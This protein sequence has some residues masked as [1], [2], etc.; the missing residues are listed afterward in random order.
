MFGFECLASSELINSFEEVI[1]QSQTKV[2]MV[3]D[4]DAHE[5]RAASDV[6]RDG[7]TLMQLHRSD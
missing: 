7:D 6:A 4:L 1:S 3:L 5:L 2:E